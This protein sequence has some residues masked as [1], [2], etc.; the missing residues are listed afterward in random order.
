M[1]LIAKTIETEEF[2]KING[3]DYSR[4]IIFETVSNDIKI[5][6]YKLVSFNDGKDSSWNSIKDNDLEEHYNKKEFIIN[7]THIDV[8]ELIKY[9]GKVY[10]KT[11]SNWP[12]E[13]VV[14]YDRNYESEKELISIAKEDDPKNIITANVWRDIKEIKELEEKYK[15]TFE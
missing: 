4:Q 2:F 7:K 14:W 10:L 3:D 11:Y 8:E 12:K 9:K 15:K 13:S 1:E 6:W 5:K